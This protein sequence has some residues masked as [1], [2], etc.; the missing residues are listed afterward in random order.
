MTTLD[1]PRGP[2]APDRPV[3]D[4]SRVERWYGRLDAIAYVGLLNLLVIAFSLAGGIVLGWA[5]ALSAATSCSR[6][7]LRGEAQKPLRAF[8]TQWRRRFLH[9]NLLA[10]PSAAALACLGVSLAALSGRPGTGGL[11][12]ALAA[13]AAV[14]LA[15]LVLALTMDA[16]YDLRRAQCI[17]LAWAFL[18]RF[19]GAP[20]LLIATTALV[21]AITGFV[22]GLLPVLSIG[23][24]VHLCTALCLSFYA[25]NDRNLPGAD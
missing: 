17:R 14:C 7:R 8:A 20:L 4:G 22:P 6:A 3:R 13:A 16:H 12:I 1:T 19:P 21:A 10:A 18:V 9:A 5:P 2:A 11:Q 23:V 25:A 15:H 24:W